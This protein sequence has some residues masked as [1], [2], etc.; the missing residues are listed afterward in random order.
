MAQI[1][2][3]QMLLTSSFSEDGFSISF[4]KLNSTKYWKFEVLD[5]FVKASCISPISSGMNFS[6]LFCE[7][8]E[9]QILKRFLSAFFC[10]QKLTAL[11]KFS[12]SPFSVFCPSLNHCD[13]QTARH[14]EN[15]VYRLIVFERAIFNIINKIDNFYKTDLRIGN[16]FSAYFVLIFETINCAACF[17]Q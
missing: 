5:S 7:M 4:S 15:H 2:C 6:T 16:F 14:P 11:L 12:L 3:A 17:N 8:F 9:K 10:R 13:F 1:K